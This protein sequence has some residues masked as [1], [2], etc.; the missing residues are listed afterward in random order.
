MLTL[1]QEFPPTPSTSPTS[2]SLG[3]YQIIA[4]VYANRESKYMYQTF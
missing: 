2:T 3:F 1:L 4:H